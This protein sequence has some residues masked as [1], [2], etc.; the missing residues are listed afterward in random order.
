MALLAIPIMILNAL[1]GIVG[2][3]WLAY[4]G[5]WHLVM[6]AL[7][8]SI[9]GTFWVSLLLLPSLLFAAPLVSSERLAKSIFAAVPLGILSVGWTY[10]VMGAWA[11]TIFWYFSKG[12]EPAAA[13]PA[14]LLSYSTA[15]SVWSYLAQKEDQQNSYS[16]MSSFFN[17][18]GSISLMAYTFNNFGGPRISEM[19]LWYGIP[20]ALS[21]VVQV[22][23]IALAIKGRQS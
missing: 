19:A 3:I 20:M 22:A 8:L 2:G 15:T 18:L 7:F 9:G 16:A 5:E 13:L 12:V 11:L 17:Q 10:C 6:I 14:L 21:L 23:M 4:I 1:S